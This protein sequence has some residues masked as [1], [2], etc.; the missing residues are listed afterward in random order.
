MRNARDLGLFFEMVD[1]RVIV[2]ISGDDNVN[3]T[4][5]RRNLQHQTNE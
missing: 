4:H 3:D 1:K 2:R 5:Q